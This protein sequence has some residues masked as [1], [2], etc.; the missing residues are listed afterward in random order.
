[1]LDLKAVLVAAMIAAAGG[2]IVLWYYHYFRRS[3]ELLA[4]WAEREGYELLHVEHRILGRGPFWFSAK[5]QAI[6]RVVVMDR[7]GHVRKGFVRL[8]DWWRGVM[9]D[10][11]EARMDDPDPGLTRA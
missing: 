6:Y 11:V 3:R 8:G 5:S 1:M 10:R 4:R 9:A 2:I 7:A